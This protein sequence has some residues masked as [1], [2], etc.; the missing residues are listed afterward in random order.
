[1]VQRGRES[2]NWKEAAEEEGIL[3]DKKSAE[4]H[5]PKRLRTEEGDLD[6]V[7]K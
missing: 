3:K 4:W 1:M 6:P 5:S 2:R 7:R